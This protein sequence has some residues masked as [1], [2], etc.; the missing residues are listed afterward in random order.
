[1]A[2]RGW[3][4]SEVCGNWSAFP[5]G[6]VTVKGSHSYRHARAHACDDL[7][8]GYHVLSYK[9]DQVE[10]KQLM[11]EQRYNIVPG[12]IV[13]E[14]CATVNKEKMYAADKS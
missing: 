12:I 1:M 2:A 4:V 11:M 3:G 10:V 14:N 7:Y 8:H 5:S 6:Q 9:T 13:T